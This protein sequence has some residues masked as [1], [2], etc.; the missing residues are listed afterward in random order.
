MMNFLAWDQKL[1]E[2]EYI[3]DMEY[4]EIMIPTVDTTKVAYTI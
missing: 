2:F 3:K 4:H 1:Q